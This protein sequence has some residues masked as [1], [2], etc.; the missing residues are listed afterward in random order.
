MSAFQGQV[1]SH[2]T[3]AAQNLTLSDRLIKVK[4]IIRVKH[5]ESKMAGLTPK[6]FITPIHAPH[7]E[8]LVPN[9]ER[10]ISKLKKMR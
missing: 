6:K 9:H 8:I 7:G 10:F 5:E 3:K 1:K 4:E 2:L